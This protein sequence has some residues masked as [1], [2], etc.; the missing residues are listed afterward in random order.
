M[1]QF[2]KTEARRIKLLVKKGKTQYQIARTLHTRKQNVATYLK[3]AN[4]GK[5]T[6]GAARFW[7]D[8]KT[9]KKLGEYE[10]KEAIRVTK[11]MPKWLKRR[12]AKL[13][14]KERR[15]HEGWAKFDKEFRASEFARTGRPEGMTD[16]MYEDYEDY[17]ETP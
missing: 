5:R 6:T 13:S 2:S 11:M 1:K 15:F 16:K 17:W 10:R 8:V 12:V 3:K 14:E 4:I 9:T 7:E